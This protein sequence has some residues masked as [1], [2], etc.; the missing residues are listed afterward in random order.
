MA[1]GAAYA[2]EMQSDL[3]EKDD[4]AKD[5]WQGSTLADVLAGWAKGFGADLG[6]RGWAVPLRGGQAESGRSVLAVQRDCGGR[7]S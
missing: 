2:V 6:A 5:L 1:E 4:S 7:K 3:Q